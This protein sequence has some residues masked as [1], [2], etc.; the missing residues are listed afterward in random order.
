MY[1]SGVFTYFIYN[2]YQLSKTKQNV[3]THKKPKSKV[4]QQNKKSIFSGRNEFV[5]IS[6]VQIMALV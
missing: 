3:F 1:V 5:C 2:I 6:Y 4:F